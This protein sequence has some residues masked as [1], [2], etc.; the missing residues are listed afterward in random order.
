M[1]TD[2]GGGEEVPVALFFRDPSRMSGLERAALADA[3]GR[4]LDL[5][6]CAGALSVP[7]L[8]SGVRVT[9]A[10]VLPTARRILAERGVTDVRAG[11]LEAL[12]PDERFET[13]LILMNGLGLAGSLAGLTPFLSPVAGRLTPAGRILAD[14]TDPTDWEDPGDGR[15]PGEVHMQL[16]FEGRSAE[17]F[18]FL[19]VS[20]TDLRAHA[21]A[22]GLRTEILVREEDGRYLA[23]LTPLPR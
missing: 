3:T 7:L 23:R 13:V 18:P 21:A 4:T 17:P 14:S 9:A 12:G 5:G 20:P 2:A 19:F 22:A 16:A 11:G 15:A 1:T 6:A 8:E 10:E